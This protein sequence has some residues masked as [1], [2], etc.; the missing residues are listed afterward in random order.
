MTNPTNVAVTEC[1]ASLAA[2]NLFDGAMTQFN[3]HILLGNQR[4]IAEARSQLHDR[5]D[6]LLDAKAAHLAAVMRTLR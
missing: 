5:L 1:V 2:Q 6:A 3:G 4:V